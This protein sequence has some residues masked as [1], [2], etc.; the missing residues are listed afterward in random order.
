MAEDGY[1]ARR[2]EDGAVDIL[3]GPTRPARAREVR[4][5]REGVGRPTG[6]ERAMAFPEEPR[7]ALFA[8]ACLMVGVMERWFVA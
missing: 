4:G 3:M 1:V 5:A 8:L 7:D 6:R 2:E